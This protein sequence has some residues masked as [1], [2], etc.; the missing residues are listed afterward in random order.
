MKNLRV[1]LAA[2]IAALSMSGCSERSADL[3]APD[4]GVY[5]GGHTFGGGNRSDSTTASSGT[6]G[7][8]AGAAEGTGGHTFGGGN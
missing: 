8:D 3:F 1:V 2:L 6:A 4:G 7:A 5:N